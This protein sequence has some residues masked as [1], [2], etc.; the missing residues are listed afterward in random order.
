MRKILAGLIVS[1]W[2]TVAFGQT[3]QIPLVTGPQ[4]SASL[5]GTLNQ[6]INRVN[7]LRGLQF[8]QSLTANSSANLLF[9]PLPTTYNSFFITCDGISPVTNGQIFQLQFVENGTIKST[10]YNYQNI[11]MQDN[12]AA[13]AP[14]VNTG[15]SGFNLGAVDVTGGAGNFSAKLFVANV[16][17]S[18]FTKQVTGQTEYQTSGPHQASTTVAGAYSGDTNQITGFNFKFQTNGILTGTCTVYGLAL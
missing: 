2:A 4:D 15:D 8:I 3:N 9:G 10:S 11:L 16:L 13:F 12:T 18:N 5:N 17:N 14:Q 1:L 6:I 7:A